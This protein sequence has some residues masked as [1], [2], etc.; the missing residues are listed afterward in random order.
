MTKTN[1]ST[2]RIALI[3]AYQGPG[4]V[5][6]AGAGRTRT[7]TVEHIDGLGVTRREG[8]SIDFGDATGCEAMT[9]ELQRDG[10]SVA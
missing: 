7:I 3:R 1:T 4:W 10:W 8:Y 9:I 6:F 2:H 5:T